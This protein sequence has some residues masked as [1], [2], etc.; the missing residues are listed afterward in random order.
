MQ[1]ELQIGPIILPKSP[2]DIWLL[3]KVG[4]FGVSTDLRD[5]LYS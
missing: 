2:Y 4:K 1:T 5:N 3:R